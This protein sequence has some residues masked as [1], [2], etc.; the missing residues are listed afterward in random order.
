MCRTGGLGAIM[1]PE[2]MSLGL[3]HHTTL[4]HS[5]PFTYIQ[6]EQGGMINTDPKIEFLSIFEEVPCNGS[7]LNLAWHN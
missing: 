3:P 5:P 6:G 7:D 4:T 2:L 1:R